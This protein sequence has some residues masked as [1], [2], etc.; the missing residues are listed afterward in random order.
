VAS[1]KLISGFEIV[2]NEATVEVATPV[3]VLLNTSYQDWALVVFTD[4]ETMDVFPL[5]QQMLPC[6]SWCGTTAKNKK[7]RNACRKKKRHNEDGTTI[8][9][10]FLRRTSKSSYT[11]P[12]ARLRLRVGDGTVIA[13]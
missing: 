9:G 12:R 5:R 7:K 4:G 2:A 8:H 11:C 1:P 3:I 13:D 6:N 10:A